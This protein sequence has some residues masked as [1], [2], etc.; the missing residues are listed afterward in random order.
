MLS[1]A[2][3]LAEDGFVESVDR[4]YMAH[5]RMVGSPEGLGGD[6]TWEDWG[7]F[8][9]LGTH[10]ENPMTPHEPTVIRPSEHGVPADH[11][12]LAHICRGTV[13]ATRRQPGRCFPCRCGMVIYDDRIQD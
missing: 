4:L 13:C 11:D 2:E 1:E 8:R 12:G 7:V 10:Q 9:Y 3:Q 6:T 5:V